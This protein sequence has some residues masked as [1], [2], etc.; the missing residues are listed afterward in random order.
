MSKQDLKYIIDTASRNQVPSIETTGNVRNA[1]VAAIIR[2]RPYIT[3]HLPAYPLPRTPIECLNQSWINDCHGEAEILFIQRASHES[4]VWSGHIAFPGGKNEVNDKSPL[5]TVY[6]ECREEIG[7]D[8][9][10]PHFIP[11]GTLEPRRIKNLKTN[12]LTMLVIPH[13][14]L[15]VSP[16][17][18]EFTLQTS[19][20][21]ETFW[22]SLR[23]LLQ[24]PIVAYSPI[25]DAKPNQSGQKLP[26]PSTV[27]VAAI[28]LKSKKEEK[29]LHLW[30]M[31]L[32]MTQE[33]VGMKISRTVMT[34]EEYQEFKT[35]QVAKL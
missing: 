6:R 20:V 25:K 10:T 27:H 5:D 16:I 30:G 23:Y 28:P 21:A 12:E 3:D 2:W 35:K 14:F 13:I 4:D 15:Q 9:D 26:W 24:D 7:L 18:P 19:E 31:T 32:R 8:L 34:E 33:I 29:I 17:T 1:C 11:L 22:I